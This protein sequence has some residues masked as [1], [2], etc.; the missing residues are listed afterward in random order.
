MNLRRSS[1]LRLRLTNRACK[2]RSGLLL[3]SLKERL[4]PHGFSRFFTLVVQAKRSVLQLN[5]ICICSLV[6]IRIYSCIRIFALATVLAEDT[7]RIE[8]LLDSLKQ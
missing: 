1:G 8:A 2:S 7:F 3:P 6:S 4:R 5:G